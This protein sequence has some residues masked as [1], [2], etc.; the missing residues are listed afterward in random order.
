M[1]KY[2]KVYVFETEEYAL[3][4]AVQLWVEVSTSSVRDNG[5]FT[6][7][8][9]GGKTPV[10]FYRKLAGVKNLPWDKTHI[11]LVDERY[12]PLDDENS[13]FNMINQHLLSLVNLPKENI[14]NILINEENAESSSRKYEN[15]L[16]GFFNLKNNEFPA[17]DLIMLG[18]GKDGHTASLFPDGGALEEKKRIS[19]SVGREGEKY[20]RVSL[21]LPVINNAKNIVFLVSGSEKSQIMQKLIVVG[22]KSLPAAY[23]DPKNGRLF[24]LMDA[25]AGKHVDV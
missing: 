19:V 3:L 5:F 8:L 11:F 17:I 2:R 9:S 18:I 14:H 4:F 25:E 12:V 6:V 23:V 13:N 7:A 22:D 10:N 16:I 24:I 15:E 20:Q 21:T 1:T